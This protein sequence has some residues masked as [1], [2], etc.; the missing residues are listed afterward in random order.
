MPDSTV[1]IWLMDSARFT[2][3]VHQQQVVSV[4]GM[5]TPGDEIVFTAIRDGAISVPEAGIGS[6][7]RN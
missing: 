2:G 7:R 3:R 6:G 4:S 1:E 5:V